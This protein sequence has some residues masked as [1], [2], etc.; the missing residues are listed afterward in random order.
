MLVYAMERLTYK[1]IDTE[2]IDLRLVNMAESRQ[3]VL[4]KTHVFYVCTL[5]SLVSKNTLW[6]ASL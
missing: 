2:D 5:V 6:Y 3:R 1:D 4:S